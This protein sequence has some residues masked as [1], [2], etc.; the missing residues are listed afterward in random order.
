MLPAG[1]RNDRHIPARIGADKD[2]VGVSA[3]DQRAIAL[4]TDGS[5]WIWGSTTEANLGTAPQQAAETAQ[6]K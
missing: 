5:S 4:A 3:G 2:W 6:N 1:W